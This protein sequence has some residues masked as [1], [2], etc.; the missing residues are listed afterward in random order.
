MKHILL[1]A[2]VLSIPTASA[3]AVTSPFVTGSARKVVAN[4]SNPF[5]NDNPFGG[6]KRTFKKEF[7]IQ[8]QSKAR[9]AYNGD[10]NAVTERQAKPAK[11]KGTH[12]KPVNNRRAVKSSNSGND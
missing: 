7:N 1:F 3:H 2:L 4:G 9:G 11:K 5:N 8:P 6:D 10:E 12:R